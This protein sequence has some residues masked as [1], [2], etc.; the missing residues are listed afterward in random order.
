MMMIIHD[1]RSDTSGIEVL[2]SSD[3][4][5]AGKHRSLLRWG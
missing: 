3:A 4:I 2:C 5:N 1:D